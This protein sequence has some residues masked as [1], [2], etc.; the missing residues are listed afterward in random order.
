MQWPRLVQKFISEDNKTVHIIVT[1]ASWS[2][3]LN[4]YET[5]VRLARKK[6]GK[7]EQ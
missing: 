5:E 3:V 2:K 4:D 6:G 7:C 1:S